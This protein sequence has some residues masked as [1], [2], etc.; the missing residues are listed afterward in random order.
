MVQPSPVE[1]LVDQLI[2]HL[3]SRALP[4][5]MAQ[6]VGVLDARVGEAMKR[7]L[8]DLTPKPPSPRPV[9]S[10]NGPR[11]IGIAELETRLGVNRATVYRWYRAGSF[12]KPHFIG[13][14][15]A[16]W[17]HEVAAW[18]DSRVGRPMTERRNNLRRANG[19]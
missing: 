19:S 14:R 8:K 3:V 18:E 7:L 11:R 10:S 9:P 17:L 13:N 16:W 6:A 15:R 1:A 4:R 5:V 2:E 12:P